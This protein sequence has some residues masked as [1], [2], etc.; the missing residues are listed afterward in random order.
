M[1]VGYP[2]GMQ[3]FTG[4][5]SSRPSSQAFSPSGVHG[6]LASN[7]V[8]VPYRGP[9]GICNPPLRVAAVCNTVPLYQPANTFRALSNAQIPGP[10]FSAAI[11]A[12]AS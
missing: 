9:V 2:L 6:R 4:L 7:A 5:T 10:R 11:C 1:G 3:Q 8:H 12:E